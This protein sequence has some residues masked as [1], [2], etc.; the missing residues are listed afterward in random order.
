MIHH[1]EVPADHDPVSKISAYWVVFAALCIFTIVSFVVNYMVRQNHLT[2]EM[3]FTLILGVA[4]VKALLVAMIFMHL[5]WDWYKLYFLIVPTF[6]LAPM[7]VLALL[8]DLV[9]YWKNFY[10]K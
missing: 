3:G 4:V 1:A 8:P 7:A 2:S 9:I 5:K 6:V 10:G